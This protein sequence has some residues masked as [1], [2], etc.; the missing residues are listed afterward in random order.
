MQK[1][2]E[3]S[4][5]VT[6]L[7]GNRTLIAVIEMSQLSWVVAGI[8]PGVARHP[9]RSPRT[10]QPHVTARAGCRGISSEVMRAAASY[11]TIVIPGPTPSFFGGA[12]RAIGHGAKEQHHENIRC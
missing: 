3:L 5:C 11:C 4:R 8:V 1:L 10:F 2:D 9:R 6:L 12:R 7:N